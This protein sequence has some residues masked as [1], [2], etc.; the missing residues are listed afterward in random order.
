M[1]QALSAT[2]DTDIDG[3]KWIFLIGVLLFSSPQVLNIAI[4]SEDHIIIG[5]LLLKTSKQ[6]TLSI[7]LDQTDHQLG[8]I[9]NGNIILLLNL[10]NIDHII[11]ILVLL[12]DTDYWVGRGQGV[13]MWVQG[14]K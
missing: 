8:A 10:R 4:R 12:D 9:L 1:V 3:F 7:S 5:V 14:Q 13:L 2:Q 11:L 6:K